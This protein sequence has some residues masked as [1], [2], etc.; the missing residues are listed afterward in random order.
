MQTALSQ[1]EQREQNGQAL[2]HARTN[3]IYLAGVLSPEAHILETV[4]Q[5]HKIVDCQQR[6]TRKPG[7]KS[8]HRR[9]VGLF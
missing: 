7:N 8:Q 9:E 3:N 4:F 5:K 2:R 6:K 1:A